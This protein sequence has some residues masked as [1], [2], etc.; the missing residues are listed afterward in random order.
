MIYVIYGFAGLFLV[1]CATML[2]VFYRDRRFGMF[3]MGVTYGASGLI[4]ISI[5]H[6]W[7]LVMG[8]ALVWLLRFMGLEPRV[9]REPE[10]QSGGT[11]DAKDTKE[12]QT[13]N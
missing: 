13:N 11:K 2:F 9:V 7:P 6:W 8:F 1:L 10:A 3:I 5:P 4:A 12:T